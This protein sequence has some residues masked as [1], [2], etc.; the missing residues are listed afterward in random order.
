MDA[1]NKQIYGVLAEFRNPKELV[2]AASSVK[3]SGYQ[4]FDTYA[5]FPIHGME[6][7]MGLKKSPLGWIVLGGA[8]TGMIG[9]LAL[10]IW[11]MGYEYP[12]N[13]SGKPFINFPIY[14]PITFEITV[15]LAAFAATFGMLAL[16]K[17]PRLYN[18]LFNVERFSKAS[19]DGFFVHIEASDDLFS[20]EKVKKLFQD[21]GA[22]HIETVYDSE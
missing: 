12:M 3:K 8:L 14:V 7:A 19:D 21:N 4:D 10:M 5:P 17:L 11:V 1:E 13:I 20:E 2:D 22:T 9:A 16:N 15:L 6:K 18:P